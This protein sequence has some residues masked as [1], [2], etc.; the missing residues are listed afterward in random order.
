[1]GFLDKLFKKSVQTT[2]RETPS[3]PQQH[4]CKT[5]EEL[6]ELYGGIALEK[7]LD[8][9][10]LIGENNWNVNM[11]TGTLSFGDALTFPIQVLGTFSHSSETWLWSWANEKAG[12][13]EHL[14]H[15]ALKLKKYGEENGI[16]LL[17]NSTFDF[18]GHQLHMIGI[19]AS[20]M[21]NAD[22]Y[23]IADYGAGAMVVT[24][25]DDRIKIARNNSTQRVMTIFS[26]VNFSV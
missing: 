19:I 17:R 9:G 23:Y 1:M 21:S 14:M 10:G 5:E 18:S 26:T 3:V 13:S 22:A 6:L 24:L 16:D 20:E 12:L 8:F 2:E 7:Q 25:T 11:Q 4:S 15:E